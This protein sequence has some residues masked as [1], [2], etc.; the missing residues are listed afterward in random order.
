MLN[1]PQITIQILLK[2]KKNMKMKRI[3][4]E[5]CDLYE[6]V[7]KYYDQLVGY[8]IKN[9][10]DIELSKDIVQEVMLKLVSAH[11]RSFKIHN[12]KAWLYEVTR[13]SIADYYRNLNNK[14]KSSIDSQNDQIITTIEKSE[15]SL[16][17]YVVL[18]IK[19]LPS[20]YSEP[21]YLSDIQ[22]LPQLI[23]AEKMGL[24]L[25]ATKMR[26]Q[27]ARKMFHELFFECCNIKYSK[28]GTFSHCTVKDTCH[29]LIK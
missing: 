23:V 21:L 14:N 20:K 16:S 22:N 13:H 6:I 8:L 9:I 1:E 15:F 29:P 2:A 12:I 4:N 5:C 26:I 25:S 24:S 18:M 3:N 27:R 10:H 7:N 28:D 11:N 19:L 17:E